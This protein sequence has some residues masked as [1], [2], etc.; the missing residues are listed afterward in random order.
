MYF[1]GSIIF[2]YPVLLPLVS[3]YDHYW[4]PYPR[5]HKLFV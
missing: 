1:I 3:V 4:R 2:A 5:L